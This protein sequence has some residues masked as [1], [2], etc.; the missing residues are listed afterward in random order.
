MTGIYEGL[1]AQIIKKCSV[2]LFA[3]CFAQSLNL[4]GSHAVKNCLEAINVF[5]VVQKLYA[6]FATSTHRWNFFLN[7]LKSEE[8]NKIIVLKL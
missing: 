7:G 8:K 6:F 5:G 3:P 1:Q 2:D 4:V